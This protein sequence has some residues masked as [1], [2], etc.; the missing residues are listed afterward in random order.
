MDDLC[1]HL[2]RREEHVV[3]LKLFL[4]KC[5]LYI[6]CLNQE[7]CVFMVRQGK[8]LGHIVSA[9]GIATDQYKIKVILELPRPMHYKGVQIFMGHCGYYRRFI[10]MYAE[11]ARPLYALLVEFN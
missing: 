8:I 1:I 7:K 10:Y 5:R 2:S 6:I 3:H 9:N 4:E 11:I